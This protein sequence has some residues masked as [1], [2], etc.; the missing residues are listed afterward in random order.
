MFQLCLLLDMSFI[1]AQNCNSFGKWSF[2]LCQLLEFPFQKI[3]TASFQLYRRWY[4]LMP[5]RTSIYTLHDMFYRIQ[6]LLYHFRKNLVWSPTGGCTLLGEYFC[7][8]SSLHWIHQFSIWNLH[9]PHT[10]ACNHIFLGLF[11]DRTLSCLVIFHKRC[12]RK[13]DVIWGFNALQALLVWVL[14]YGLK[15]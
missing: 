3:R 9:R 5:Y 1:V 14:H 10:W 4:L 6:L 15:L 11:C 7:F 2:Y 8:C 13:F 12:V